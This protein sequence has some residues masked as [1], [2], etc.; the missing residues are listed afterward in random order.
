MTALSWTGLLVLGFALIYLPYLPE[1]YYFGTAI[2]SESRS[3]FVTAVYLSM[4]ALATLGLGD[5]AP[6]APGLR[7][8]VPLEALVGFIL[9]SAVISWVL[10]LYPALTRRRALARRLS[11]MA[12]TGATT[13]DRLEA[14]TAVQLLE[15]VRDSVSTIEMDLLQYGE[16]YYFRERTMSVRRRG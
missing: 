3:G 4:V 2:R 12:A 1:D 14:S 15:G 6:A 11:T 16:S 13:L 8:A 9:L 10:Q 7:I 5:I